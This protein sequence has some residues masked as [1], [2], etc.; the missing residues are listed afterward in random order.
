M[1][2]EF[3]E[4]T[5]LDLLESVWAQF[6]M[7]ARGYGAEPGM[8]HDGG[9]SVLTEVQEVLADAGRL[10]GAGVEGKDWWWT[11]SRPQRERGRR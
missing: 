1:R 7:E 11:P 2:D 10:V 5:L 9:L 8:R 4:E 3:T 6:S